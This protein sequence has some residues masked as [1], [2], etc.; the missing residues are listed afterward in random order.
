MRV[1]SHGDRSGSNGTASSSDSTFST[2]RIDPGDTISIDRTWCSG[3]ACSS[4]T[5]VGRMRVNVDA[6]GRQRRRGALVT[7]RPN[8]RDELRL[9]RR[10]I[11]EQQGPDPEAARGILAQ[12]P[13][14]RFDGGQAR[15]HRSSSA[16]L[17]LILQRALSSPRR[18]D[19]GA[20][21]DV[22]TGPVARRPPPMH[23]ARAP[24][25]SVFD[26]FRDGAEEV[27]QSVS[28]ELVPS[29]VR[30][31][32][33]DELIER[34]D[35]QAI[36]DRIDVEAV[37]ERVDLTRLLERVDLEVVLARLDVNEI[38]NRVDIDGLLERTELGAVIS[39]SG[40]A[41]A[42]RALDAARSQGVG[43]DLFIERWTNRL[44]RR[45]DPG[46]AARHSTAVDVP[47]STG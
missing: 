23:A 24:R 18:S 40:S 30:A 7:A 14:D 33:V 39:R 6:S 22:D 16:L 36:V 11:E 1:T 31:L 29:V 43:L 12:S 44:L 47:A 32:D 8:P 38:L 13:H 5:Q 46:T 35:V 2:C 26:S 34:I 3:S 19:A 41:V 4:S 27:I 25:P 21:G 10:P 15:G 28:N 17:S 9:L 45:R 42:A 20:G 37:L